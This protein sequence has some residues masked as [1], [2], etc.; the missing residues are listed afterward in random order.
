MQRE[1][2]NVDRVRDNSLADGVED[3]QRSKRYW[4]HLVDNLFRRLPLYL[5]PIVLMLFLGATLAQK[6]SDD[7]VSR[8]TIDASENPLVGELD[9]RGT[10]S[11]GFRQTAAQ[12]TADFIGEQL[13]TD[14]FATDVANAAGLGDALDNNL[15]TPFTIRSSIAVTPNGDSIIA[16]RS[17]W[18]D[19]VT[20]QLIGQATI[21]T[22]RAYVVDTVAADGVAAVDF[23]TQLQ[24]QAQEQVA[25]AQ[26]SL[27]DYVATLPVLGKD[28]NRP[29]EQD[30]TVQR[31]NSAL[32]RAQ[33]NVQNATN[34]IETARLQVAQSRSEAGQSVRVIDPPSLPVVP[35]PKL[36]KM[37]S[38]V[39]VFGV[40]GV[41]ISSTALVLTTALDRTIR[42]DLDVVPATGSPI[43]ATVPVIDSLLPSGGRFRRWRDVAGRTR[44]RGARSQTESDL[45][46]ETRDEPG[47]DHLD[48][49]VEH[50]VAAEPVA[51]DVGDEAD[52]ADE[53]ASADE[54]V[55][56]ASADEPVEADVADEAEVADEPDE[57]DEPVDAD[58]ASDEEPAADEPVPASTGGR[59]G[60]RRRWRTTTGGTAATVASGEGRR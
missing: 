9:V 1:G 18:S 6:T 14:V 58:E 46:D 30:L 3:S 5:V 57:P 11:T 17:T 49:H 26:K 4:L 40:L 2:V 59:N 36:M 47:D 34:E 44:R 43:V 54:P 60:S 35:E 39:L 27:E 22:Y 16:V 45:V 24:N 53:P 10:Q 25:A 42:F 28:E 48:E 13:R 12:T 20:A 56:P 38:V 23:Y 32:D 21:D 52:E 19:P 51:T 41:L 7:Y 8:A 31:L 15:I 37:I 50:D 29:L 55:E 33:E